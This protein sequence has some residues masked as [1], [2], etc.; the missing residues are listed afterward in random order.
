MVGV[1]EELDKLQEAFAA[2]GT[3][4]TRNRMGTERNA[5]PPYTTW[6]PSAAGSE[7]SHQRHVTAREDLH[8]FFSRSRGSLPPPP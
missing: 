7:C 6:L 1:A 5:V 4:S 8:P 2:F 3:L